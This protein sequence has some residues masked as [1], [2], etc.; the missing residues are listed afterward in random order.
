MYQKRFAFKALLYVQC[1]D[2]HIRINIL[3][4]FKLRIIGN[5]FWAM[6]VF[7]KAGSDPDLEK[8]VR[9]RIKDF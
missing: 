6:Y 8:K 2:V 3:N 9:I 1:Y 7:F 5:I 4:I